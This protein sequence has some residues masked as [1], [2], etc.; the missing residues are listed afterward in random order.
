MFKVG[1]EIEVY[2]DFDEMKEKVDYYLSHEDQRAK[3]AANGHR[4]VKEYYNY[5]RSLKEMFAK[6][7]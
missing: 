1:T 3:I 4:K 2:K 5:D 7:I 6:I